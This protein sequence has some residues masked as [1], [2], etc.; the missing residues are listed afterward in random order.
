M[1]QALAVLTSF[2][3][4]PHVASSLRSVLPLI[5]ANDTPSVKLYQEVVAAALLAKQ[6]GA[7]VDVPPRHGKWGACRLR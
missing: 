4:P 3:Q 7:Y 2:V 5:S 6:V 1:W